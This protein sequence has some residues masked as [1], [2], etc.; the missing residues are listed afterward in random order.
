LRPVWNAGT[1]TLQQSQI[2][3]VNGQSDQFFNQPS[4]IQ[5]LINVTGLAGAGPVNLLRD[6]S[7]W[8]EV[9]DSQLPDG[10][11]GH[12]YMVTDAQQW[13]TDSS[14]NWGLIQNAQWL[15]Q[16]VKAFRSLPSN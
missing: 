14:I 7:G 5:E 15:R 16:G 13:A 4:V 11:A 10:V 6:G 3:A 9:Q 1:H 2:R 12:G 8:I